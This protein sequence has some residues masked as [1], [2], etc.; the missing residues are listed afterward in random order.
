MAGFFTLKYSQTRLK[1]TARDDD[2]WFVI[3]GVRYNQEA[4]Y[5]TSIHKLT[6]NNLP[7]QIMTERDGNL[8]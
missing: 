6:I 7:R 3:T 2:N 5:G 1:R 8:N 4:F